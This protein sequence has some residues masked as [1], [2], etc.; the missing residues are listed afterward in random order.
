MRFSLDSNN[1]MKMFQRI[2]R[3]LP[4]DWLYSVVKES[5]WNNPRK[6]VL[7]VSLWNQLPDY[8]TWYGLDSI[9]REFGYR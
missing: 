6:K 9:L 8:S 7:M 4:A 5:K 3:E 1:A 2:K